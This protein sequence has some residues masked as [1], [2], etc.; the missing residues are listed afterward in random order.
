MQDIEVLD[1]LFKEWHQANSNQD[2]FAIINTKTARE[3]V[4]TKR[5]YDKLHYFKLQSRNFSLPEE[6]RALLEG[7]QI[8][9]CGKTVAEFLTP[10]PSRRSKKDPIQMLNECTF[11]QRIMLYPSQGI[12]RRPNPTEKAYLAI[13][14]HIT[15]GYLIAYR[16]T[17]GEL[18]EYKSYDVT[19]L[20]SLKINLFNQSNT[21]LSFCGYELHQIKLAPMFHQYNKYYELAFT[22][23]FDHLGKEISSIV[24]TFSNDEESLAALTK[25]IHEV[26]SP[27]EKQKRQSNVLLFRPGYKKG[28]ISVIKKTKVP[29]NETWNGHYYLCLCRCGKLITLRSRKIQETD[30]PSCGCAIQSH[31]DLTGKV[32]GKL[33]VTSETK[34]VNR[35]WLWKAICT[36]GNTV[37][38]RAHHLTS[39]RSKSCGRC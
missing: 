1:Q 14:E 4:E 35:H 37:W 8:L 3:S 25:Q 27:P 12:P 39:G 22:P 7:Y 33:T 6:V 18:L 31:R 32:Y 34:R 23:F 21:H 5:I 30:T 19:Q 17:T 16:T 36:C 2:G 20:D 28:H 9:I 26:N 10:T 38:P 24:L 15:F 13:K 11:K 29:D